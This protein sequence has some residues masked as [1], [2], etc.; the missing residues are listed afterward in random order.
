MVKGLVA[1]LRRYSDKTID[2]VERGVR[3]TTEIMYNESRRRIAVDT[4]AT[5][6]NIKKKHA[7]LEGVVFM[8][9]MVGVWLEF[10]T[11]V[12]ATGPGGSRAKKIPWTYYKDGKFYT[13][14]GMMAQ[15]FWYPSLDVTRQYFKNYFSN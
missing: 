7:D 10:G 8:T 4:G 6:D 11:G 5:R 14:Y 15:P 2:E 12:H 13:T 9:S 1:S 3:T